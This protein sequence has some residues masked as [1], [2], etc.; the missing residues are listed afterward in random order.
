VTH[1]IE[2]N[3]LRAESCRAS[4]QYPFHVDVEIDRWMPLLLAACSGQ[5]TGM[6]LYELMRQQEH[7]PADTEPAK[8]AA[9]LAALVSSGFIVVPEFAPPA[10]VRAAAA[11]Q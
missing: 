5:R 6:E 11:S 7:I 10:I 3:E 8:F 4:V 2:S 9:L 1:I